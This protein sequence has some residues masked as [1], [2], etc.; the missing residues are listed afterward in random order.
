MH[1]AAQETYAYSHDAQLFDSV[2]TG[3]VLE[4]PRYPG[5]LGVEWVDWNALRAR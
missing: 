3:S 5:A 2:E 4:V 1:G